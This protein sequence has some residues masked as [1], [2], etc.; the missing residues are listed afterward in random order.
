MRNYKII[1]KEQ[2]LQNNLQRIEITKQFTKNRNYK[3]IYTDEKLQNNLQRTEIT[4]L[5]TKNR[6]NKIIYK[7]QKLQ[8]NL[9]NTLNEQVGGLGS[10]CLMS[11]STIFQ[12]YRGSQFYWWRKPENSE[13]PTNLSQFTDKLYNLML[14]RVPSVRLV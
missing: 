7:E 11:L 10:G 1:Y 2:K 9:L 12:L 4:K 8:N 6:N 13:K 14:Y 5:F 3:I